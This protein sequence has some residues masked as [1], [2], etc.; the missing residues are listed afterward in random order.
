M[1]SDFQCKTYIL[2]HIKDGFDND[3]RPR[4]PDSHHGHEPPADFTGHSLDKGLRFKLTFKFKTMLLFIFCEHNM[5]ESDAF[6]K[7]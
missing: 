1:I 7:R 3:T 6:I 5:P 2:I 4:Q